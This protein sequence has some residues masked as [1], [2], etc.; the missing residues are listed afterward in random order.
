M[1]MIGLVSYLLPVAGEWT[2]IIW[3]PISACIFY[4]L[5][6]GRYGQIGALINFLE[7]IIPFTD[8]IPTFTI[9]YFYEKQK[10]KEYRNKQTSLSGT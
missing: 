4:K 6:G 3:A 1:D 8:V 2:D 10:E 5:I 7:E 9:M